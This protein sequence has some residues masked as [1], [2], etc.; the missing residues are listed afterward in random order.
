M[1]G[2]N[3]MDLEN[4]LAEAVRAYSDLLLLFGVLISHRYLDTHYI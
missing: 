4:T 1:D 2:V 3:R